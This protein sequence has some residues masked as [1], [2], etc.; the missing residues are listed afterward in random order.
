MNLSSVPTL[1]TVP[2]TGT[3]YR[4]TPPQFYPASIFQLSYTPRIASRFSAGPYSQPP[5]Q[6]LYLA[7][8]PEMALL[9]TENVYGRIGNTVAN[10]HAVTLYAVE[11]QTFRLVNLIDPGVQ[12]RLQTS[13]QELTGNW[14]IYGANM[15]T[16]P[17]PVFLPTAPTQ[18]LGA[19]LFA[20]GFEGLI[21]PSAK[22]PRFPS[23]MLFP[24]NLQANSIVT[25][26]DPATGQIHR[27]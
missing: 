1:P 7:Q 27:V 15:P 11:V 6:T 2:R 21:A 18:L 4:A 20:E 5:Y 22:D 10:L 3:W 9:E 25:H 12:A 17:F 26:T 16:S 14:T 19:A 24:Q 8:T 23:L 13:T